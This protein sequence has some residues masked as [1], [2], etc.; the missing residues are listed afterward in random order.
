MEKHRGKREGS[1]IKS[2]FEDVLEEAVNPSQPSNF[3]SF[4][5]IFFHSIQ[6]AKRFI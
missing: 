3:R 1:A 5:T 6:A 4:W 2:N